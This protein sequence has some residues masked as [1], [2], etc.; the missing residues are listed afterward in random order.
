M[1]SESAKVK[2]K[3][4]LKLR[5]SRLEKMADGGHGQEQLQGQQ[6]Q[7]EQEHFF[8][9]LANRNLKH[10]LS[11]IL[12][13]LPAQDIRSCLWTCRTLRQAV[14]N[15]RAALNRET[16]HAFWQMK[17]DPERK[18]KNEKVIGMEPWKASKE[19]MGKVKVRF[20]PDKDKAEKVHDGNEG[21][22]A[23]RANSL[24]DWEADKVIEGGR[25]GFLQDFTDGLVGFDE[26]VLSGM[27]QLGLEQ[28]KKS[29][30]GIL[31]HHRRVHGD[32]LFY[33]QSGNRRSCKG[34]GDSEEK[35]GVCDCKEKETYLVR[36]QN[37]EKDKI[38]KVLGKMDYAHLADREEDQI[39]R[40][41][42]MG[43]ELMRRTLD[44]FFFFL[45][46]DCATAALLVGAACGKPAAE[47]TRSSAFT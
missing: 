38:D 36:L 37:G 10:V 19:F 28:S 33:A 14:R 30:D 3:V 11:N 26:W 12:S 32:D 45:I 1:R 46:L 40:L 2:V 27:E 41:E 6:E 7:Q 23:R 21:C 24:W 17:P 9:G 16:A 15:D 39:I 5:V 31:F 18:E 25:E 34:R 4:K 22:L 43:S 13:Y 35:Q 29:E 42:W 20:E 47:A 8:S 44:F